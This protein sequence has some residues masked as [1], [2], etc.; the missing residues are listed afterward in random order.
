MTR[1]HT[2]HAM[3]ANRFLLCASALAFTVVVAGCSS[4]GRG[5]ASPTTTI[6]TASSTAATPTTVSRSPAVRNLARC[7]SGPDSLRLL[8]FR[9]AGVAGVAERL[10]PIAALDVRLCNYG[11][12]GRLASSALGQSIAAG[13]LATQA[14]G[15]QKF[16][17][18][19][20]R[21]AC[22]EVDVTLL[23]FASDSQQVSIET[24]GCGVNVATNGVLTVRPS[25]TW[26]DG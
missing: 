12:Q 23:I 9:N 26:L 11:P 16:T 7:P 3:P 21:L 17:A 24:Y 1:R 10:V 15:F 13:R 6:A 20:R 2:G 5:Q 18:P 19:Q 4:G 14:N 8:A 25:N 22:R